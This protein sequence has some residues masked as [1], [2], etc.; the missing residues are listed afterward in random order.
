MIAAD[1]YGVKPDS[2]VSPRV[3]KIAAALDDLND[4]DLDLIETFITR[5]R[6]E[7]K[8]PAK[9]SLKRVKAKRSN[10]RVA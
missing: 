1:W 7:P 10:H 5:L 4:D 6:P 8:V 9:K 2:D 3:Q